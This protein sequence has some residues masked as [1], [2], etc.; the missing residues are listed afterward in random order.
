MTYKSRATYPHTPTHKSFSY[1][2]IR[3]LRMSPSTENANIDLFPAPSS[4]LPHGL[5]PARWPGR[6]PESTVALREL[7][8]E[9]HER[10]HIFFNDIGFHNHI[11]HRLLALWALGA[12]EEVLKAAFKFDSMPDKERPAFSSPERITLANFHDHLR[13]E[14]YFSAYL[15]FFTDIVVAENRDVSSVLEEFVF[16][17]Q[18]ADT[19]KTQEENGRDLQPPLLISFFEGLLHALIHVG[20]GLEFGLSGMIV[21]GLALASVHRPTPGFETLVWSSH[22]TLDHKGDKSKV[23]VENLISGFNQSL[24]IDSHEARDV[25]AFTVLAR[26]MKDPAMEV[27]KVNAEDIFAILS[28]NGGETSKSLRRYADQW[29]IYTSEPE[30]V[31]RKIEEL[32]WMNVLIFAVAGFKKLKSGEFRADF[33]LMHLVTTSLF[34]P[35]LVAHL[36]LSSQE[37]LLRSYFAISLAIY[38]ARGRP[39]IDPVPL[40]EVAMN[41][42]MFD[43]VDGFTPPALNLLSS[44][45]SS[46][47]KDPNI[48]LSLITR[49]ILHP[50]DHV[51]KFQRAVAHY[52]NLYGSTPKGYFERL[53][54]ELNGVEKI[55]GTLFAKA[56][57]LAQRRLG[58]DRGGKSLVSFWDF[59]GFYEE[60]EQ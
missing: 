23:D 27:K 30:S 1:H 52:A 38:V 10:W 28:E 8:Q 39:K 6:T 40:F 4:I 51:A 15:H 11:S 37:V 46:S 57:A 58:R 12:D 7:L 54:I 55:D 21:E 29:S 36:P 56:G 34:L 35:S 59:E 17:G 31:Q 45:S 2:N 50:D 9:N 53:G 43:P 33:Y 20:Y 47:E 18:S 5:S 41:D 32:Q 14:K 25:H 3:T 19:V 44:S 24:G 26:I 22:K 48:W 16:T 42:H 13:D 49:A 60:E